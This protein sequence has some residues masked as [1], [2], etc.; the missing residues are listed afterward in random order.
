MFTWGKSDISMSI[1][2]GL[3]DKQ[4]NTLNSKEMSSNPVWMKN[5]T[6]VM[7]CSTQTWAHD[8]QTFQISKQ[9]EIT[10][11]LNWPWKY[12]HVDIWLQLLKVMWQLLTWNICITKVTFNLLSTLL[13]LLGSRKNYE[14]SLKGTLKCNSRLG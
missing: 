8:K 12:K 6:N 4:C 1:I 5:V 11:F 3:N 7:F 13:H 9:F 14:N 2:F 10:D